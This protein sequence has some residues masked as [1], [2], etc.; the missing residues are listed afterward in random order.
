MLEKGV[1]EERFKTLEKRIQRLIELH[2]SLKAAHHQLVGDNAR[3]GA[4]L[5]DERNK[6]K[7][8]EEGYRNLK[9]QETQAAR[10]QVERIN[11]RINELVGEIDKNI[12]LI[13]A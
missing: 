6:V 11:N 10:Q 7:R 8:L 2:E 9:E 12:K 13:E 1:I 3:L 4:E 5:A